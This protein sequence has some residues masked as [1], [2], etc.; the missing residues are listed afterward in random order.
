MRVLPQALGFIRAYSGRAMASFKPVVI[1][2][3]SGSGK[4]TLLQKMFKDFPG[5]FEFSVSHTTR[6]PREGETDGKDYYFVDRAVFEK[7]VAD[8]GFLEHAQFSGNCYGTSKM[9]VEKVQS[10]GKICILDVE[11]NGVKNI[12]ATDFKAKYIFVQ[13]PSM[14]ALEKRLRGRGTETEESLKKRLDTV[15][16]ALDY[17]KVPGAYDHIIINDDLDVAY[18]KLKGILCTDLKSVQ[19]GN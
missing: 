17:A 2:G 15:Q 18:E 10:S 7:M 14:E 12:K 4:S 8:G 16:E 9:A 3:P 6:K 11:I 1:S 13:P 19:N 5:C